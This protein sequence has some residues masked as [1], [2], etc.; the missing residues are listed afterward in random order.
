M[1]SGLAT[2]EMFLIKAECLARKGRITESMD[3][4]NGLLI[5]RWNKTKVYVPYI[6][7]GSAD[8]LRIV[9]LERRKE[10]MMRGLR[11]MDVKR[12]NKEGAN[13]TFT[14]TLNGKLYQLS[15]NDLRFALPIPEDVI[16]LSGMEQNKR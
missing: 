15:P 5:R 7:T 16:S 9:L 10:L 11:W 4:L 6:A 14:R 12:L 1:F 13:I 2:D 3:L 8:A